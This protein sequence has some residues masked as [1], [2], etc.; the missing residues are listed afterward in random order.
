MSLWIE[1]QMVDVWFECQRKS[2]IFVVAVVTIQ[3]K[4]GI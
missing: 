3:L 2:Y 1:V 4:T